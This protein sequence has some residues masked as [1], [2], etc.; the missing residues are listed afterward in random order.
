MSNTI[1]KETAERLYKGLRALSELS[2]PKLCANCGKRYETVDEFVFQTEA[3][4]KSSGL[5]EEEEDGQIF[6]ELFRNCICGSTLMDEFNNRR[7][8]SSAGI[9]RREKFGEILERLTG[10]G[11][12]YETARNELLK[13]M[14]GDGSELL[15]VKPSKKALS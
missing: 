5:K 13:V 4:R 1:N 7:D 12:A 6:V 9:G 15:R 11:I 8:L 3:V 14:R 2:F 10:S